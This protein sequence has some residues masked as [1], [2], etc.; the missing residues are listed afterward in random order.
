MYLFAIY[1]MKKNGNKGFEL[2]ENHFYL[3]ILLFATSVNLIA[4]NMN[5]LSRAAFYYEF[6]SIIA[7]PNIIETSISKINNRR[8]VYIIIFTFLILHSEIIMYYR[9]EW[10]SAYDYKSCIIQKY[11]YICE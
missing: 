11:D 10:N 2:R 9:P 8:L 7:F 4:T 3:Y 1:E 6:L 5:V